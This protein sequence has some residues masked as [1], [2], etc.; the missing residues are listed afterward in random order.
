MEKRI[1]SYCLSPKDKKIAF[2][3]DFARGCSVKELCEIHNVSR[4]RIGQMTIYPQ[5]MQDFRV[6][7]KA[8]DRRVQF[9]LLQEYPALWREVVS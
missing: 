5:N 3:S 1:G 9:Q 8:H 7:R 2:I 6:A 4:T